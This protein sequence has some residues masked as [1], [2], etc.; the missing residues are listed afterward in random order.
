MI[1]SAAAGD[2]EMVTQRSSQVLEVAAIF[3]HELEAKFA[4]CA[5]AAQRK[6]IAAV[7]ETHVLRL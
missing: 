4:V 5:S 2:A 1:E 6:L 7:D 3:V